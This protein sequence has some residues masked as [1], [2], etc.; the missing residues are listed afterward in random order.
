[1]KFRIRTCCFVYFP[2]P[3]R[4][5]GGRVDANDP[6]PDETTPSP[7]Q[8]VRG[9]EG[10]RDPSPDESTFSP[11]RDVRETE[12]DNDPSPEET[13]PSWCL[14]AHDYIFKPLSGKI[15]SSSLAFSV[16]FF[17]AATSVHDAKLVTVDICFGLAGLCLLVALIAAV[18]FCKE[19]IE[20]GRKRSQERA[21]R[22]GQEDGVAP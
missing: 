20:E 13:S 9:T 7:S 14:E 5:V 1:M 2:A 17:V 22:T 6:S 10:V 11:S 21:G 16:G 18:V 8:D 12:D 15:A 4:D 3:P 19:K